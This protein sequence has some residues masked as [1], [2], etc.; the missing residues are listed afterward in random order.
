M[1][2][3]VCLFIYAR[4]CCERRRVVTLCESFTEGEK[5]GGLH[6]KR[7]MEWQ[8]RWIRRRSIRMWL[9]LSFSRV[10][11]MFLSLS[12]S[13]SLSSFSLPLLSPVDLSLSFR[14]ANSDHN[15]PP[16]SDAALSS[17]NR[18]GH[19]GL[20]FAPPHWCVDVA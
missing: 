11:L 4:L 20:T 1:S 19:L 2:V 17:S 8:N 13:L 7:K 18:D 10:Y 12:L 9:W 14:L 16:I 3:Y 5:E 6:G 15:L